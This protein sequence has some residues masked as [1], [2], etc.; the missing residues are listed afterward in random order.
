MDG[1]QTSRSLIPKQHSWVFR[2]TH[3]LSCRWNQY[4]HQLLLN[5]T[6]RCPG[7]GDRLL[8]HVPA[9]L[10]NKG[11]DQDSHQIELNVS[12][13]ACGWAAPSASLSPSRGSRGF[14][15]LLRQ[16]QP[17]AASSFS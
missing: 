16:H 12:L 6:R 3:P 5:V 13:G 8:L 7:T 1:K 17:W 14:H 15:P 2:R 10:Q 9:A 4:Q 11:K